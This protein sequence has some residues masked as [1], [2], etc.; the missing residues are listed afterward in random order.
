MQTTTEPFLA[1]RWSEIAQLS[2]DH[3]LTS[4]AKW[5]E[6]LGISPVTWW[7]IRNGHAKPSAVLVA[8]LKLAFPELS[9]DALLEV[10]R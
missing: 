4:D 8:R 2:A 7:R 9:L 1:L 10:Q 6:K 5:G 3:D